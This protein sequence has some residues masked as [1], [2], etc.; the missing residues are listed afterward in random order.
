M[1][2]PGISVPSLKLDTAG[3]AFPQDASPGAFV[4][5]PTGFLLLLFFQLSFFL[6]AFASAW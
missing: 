5:F 2:E 4:C 1:A 3:V 6:E